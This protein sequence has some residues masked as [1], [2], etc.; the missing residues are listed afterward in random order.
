MRASGNPIR[1][2]RSAVPESRRS[3][4]S[5]TVDASWN[6]TITRV[7]SATMCS[8]GAM[9]A[10]SMRENSVVPASRLNIGAVMLAFVRRL[11]KRE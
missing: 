10:G 3:W 7:S 1:S 2:R 11:A 4:D 8:A 9:M 6:N 5:C